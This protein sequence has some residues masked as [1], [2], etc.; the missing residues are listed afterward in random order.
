MAAL[1][2]LVFA[3]CGISIIGRGW[4]VSRLVVPYQPDITNPA[5]AISV[6]FTDSNSQFLLRDFSVIARGATAAGTGCGTAITMNFMTDG[7][8]G[9][10][11]PRKQRGGIV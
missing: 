10:P 8:P 1:L 2:F 9:V 7:V 5:G 3:N 11:A 4:T 6:V